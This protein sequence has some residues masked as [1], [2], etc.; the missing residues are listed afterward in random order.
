M[1]LRPTTGMF[2]GSFGDIADPSSPFGAPMPDTNVPID[3][4]DVDIGPTR[5]G[6]VESIFEILMDV[7]A[8]TQ[9]T[10]EGLDPET[11]EALQTAVE[12]SSAAELAVIAQEIAEAGGYE[13]WLAQ[14]PTGDPGG[15]EPPPPETEPEPAQAVQKPPN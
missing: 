9:G 3:T 5:L 2:T 6:E 10:I 14:Q 1:A 7:M 8:G 11:I 12:R 4:G 13:E 15:S